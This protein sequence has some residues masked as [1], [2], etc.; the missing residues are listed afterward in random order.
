MKSGEIEQ[1]VIQML[2]ERF[3][4]KVP[5]TTVEDSRAAVTL[6]YMIAGEG[7]RYMINV[8]QVYEG[9]TCTC[10]MYYKGTGT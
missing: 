4:M 5:N 8:L 1:S 9:Y 10:V 7:S 3:A 6:L 2:W